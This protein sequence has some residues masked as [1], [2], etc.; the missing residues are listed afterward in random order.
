[1]QIPDI[2][3]CNP[4]T[5]VL[6]HLLSPMHGMGY[7]GDDFWTVYDCSSCYDVIDECVPYDW[8][9]GG[10]RRS[11]VISFVLNYFGLDKTE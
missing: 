11:S 10:E 7:K 9:V 3:N 2:C 1:M 4:E 8:R 6:C 5:T